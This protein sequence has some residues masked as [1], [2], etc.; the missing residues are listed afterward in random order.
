[1]VSSESMANSA[2]LQIWDILLTDRSPRMAYGLATAITGT[3]LGLDDALTGVLFSNTS[4]IPLA[5]VA[6]AAVT[7]GHGPGLL[8]AGLAMAGLYHF[9][10]A[11]AADNG[12]LSVW[13]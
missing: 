3:S 5:A 10:W 1:M 4:F 7:G 13:Q 12:T 6:L 2:P 11:P 8:A 9:F